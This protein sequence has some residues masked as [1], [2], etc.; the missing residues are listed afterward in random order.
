MNKIIGIS[1]VAGAGKD[2]FYSLL[3]QSIP[4]VKYSLADEL[5]REV[6][7]W[8]RL[9]YGIDSVTCSRKEKEVIREFLVYH[10]TIKRKNSE[11][12][13]WIDKVHDTIINDKS[14]N[15]KV[16][17]DIRYDEYE[18]DEVSWLKNELDGVLVHVSMY[19]DFTQVEVS[20]EQTKIIK[21]VLKKYKSPANAEE[22]RNDPKIKDKSDFQVEWPFI[23]NSQI[24]E[25]TPW[26][27]EFAKWLLKS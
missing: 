10:G 16:I 19:V 13:H 20:K 25:L 18:N 12:R 14:D 21:G 26:V 9:H 8:C 23:K 24:D 22:A 5:K 17:T 1:G 4:C 2:T 11:G 7:Q 3:S 15:L 27:D 6:N